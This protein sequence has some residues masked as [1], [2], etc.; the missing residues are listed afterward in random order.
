MYQKSERSLQLRFPDVVVLQAVSA[1][2]LVV[3]P[4]LLH[5]DTT[6]QI[7]ALLQDKSPEC[8]NLNEVSRLDQSFDILVIPGAGNSN[9][10]GNKQ[11]PNR[12]QKLRLEAAA[13]QFIKQ[14]YE[15]NPPKYIYS[16][17]GPQDDH[18]SA[19]LSRNYFQRFVAKTTKGAISADNNLFIVDND[20]INTSETIRALSQAV[21][22]DNTHNVGVFSQDYHLSR[23]K[24]LLCHFDNV[25]ATVLSVEEIMAIYDAEQSLEIAR[26]NATPQAQEKKVKEKLKLLTFVPG[27]MDDGYLL[28][29]FKEP[30]SQVNP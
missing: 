22:D 16:Y 9:V 8:A 30:D 10:A 12:D 24:M 5:P 18:V 27:V 2:A 29:W 28:T 26:H 14:S 3:V 17:E 4:A 25:N 7:S 6:R 20:A 15:G 19:F 21:S 13:Y 1:L 23:I 11:I